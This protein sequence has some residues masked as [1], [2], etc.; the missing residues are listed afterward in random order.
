MIG[1]L[2][3]EAG[4]YMIHDCMTIR[5]SVRYSQKDT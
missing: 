4:Q 3:S 2:V 5:W 1:R